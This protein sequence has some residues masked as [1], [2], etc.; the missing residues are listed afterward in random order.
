MGKKN[1]FMG[2]LALSLVLG[3]LSGPAFGE[4]TTSVTNSTQARLNFQIVIPTILYLQVGSIGQGNI[5]QFSCTL[6][7]FPGA[8]SIPMSCAG[9]STVPVRVTVLAASGQPV[10]LTAD[11]STKMG[12]T[13]PFTEITCAAGGVFSTYTFNNGVLALDSFTGSGLRQGTY[14]FTYANTQYHGTGTYTGQVT[15]TLASP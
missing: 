9:S 1:F 4:S 2:L 8:G 13:I 14:A 15:Y 12:G 11:S 6:N 10:K 5:D 3:L 7:K